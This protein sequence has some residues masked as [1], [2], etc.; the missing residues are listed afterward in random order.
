MDDE[1]KALFHRFIMKA[2]FLCKRA[3]SDI[4][5]GIVFLAIRVQDP[6]EGDWAKLLKLFAFLKGTIN[7]V[8][9][10]EA[11]VID[12]ILKWFIDA[13]FA[14]HPDMKSHTGATP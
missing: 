9:T 6:N 13:A 3:R 12:M 5:P 11:E 1:R 8:L 2:M 10:L 14:V 4:E 7:N